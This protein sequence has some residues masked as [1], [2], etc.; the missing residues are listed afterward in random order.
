MP[1]GTGCPPRA[2]PSGDRGAL[3]AGSFVQMSPEPPC[4]S[5]PSG[6]PRAGRLPGPLPGAASRAASTRVPLGQGPPSGGACSRRLYRRLVCGVLLRELSAHIP[7]GGSTESRSPGDLRR[8]PKPETPV[9]SRR[10]Q[11]RATDVAKADDG[12][13]DLRNDTKSFWCSH[14][15]KSRSSFTSSGPA[16]PHDDR[17][18]RMSGDARRVT[19]PCGSG[20]S[21]L[22]SS[23]A[24]ARQPPNA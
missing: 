19:A 13:T 3:I 8:L 10:W 18:G 7:M 17:Y 15:E 20:S 16:A 22:P 21:D 4:R 6:S 11:H 24:S 1:H 14:R 9:S 2:S 23:S 12:Q 5:F